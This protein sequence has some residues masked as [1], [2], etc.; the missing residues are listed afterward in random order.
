MLHRTSV[1]SRNV[2]FSTENPLV[3]LT[4]RS[5]R[6]LDNWNEVS[7]RLVKTRKKTTSVGVLP[8][9]C[10]RLLKANSPVEPVL[11]RLILTASCVL[12]AWQSVYCRRLDCNTGACG[13]TCDYIRISI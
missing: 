10:G 6:G 5:S 1:H 9:H 12:R 8:D 11:A 13:T 3:Y 4:D 7:L 2:F